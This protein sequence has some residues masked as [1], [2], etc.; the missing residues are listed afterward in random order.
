MASY[1][2]PLIYDTIVGYF[3]TKQV[4][5]KILDT[6]PDNSRILDVGIGTGYTYTKN[7]DIIKKKNIRIVGVDIDDEY[8]RQAKHA[9]IDASL[10]EYV[11]VIRG[12]IYEVKNSLLSDKS[13]DYVMFSDS[14]AVIPNVHGMCTF[15][16][17]FLKPSGSMLVTSTL[18]EEYNYYVNWIKERIVCVTTIDFGKMMI[19]SELENYIVGRGCRSSNYSFTVV[20][21]LTVP[22]FGTLLRTYMVLWQP[23]SK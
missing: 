12:D 1:L 3:Y 21:E 17:K 11:N 7:A 14:Y 22:V 18:F 15:C 6:V 13:F 19:K 20:D 5:G 23:Q 2:R 8:V 4:I 16:E 9:M 10:D